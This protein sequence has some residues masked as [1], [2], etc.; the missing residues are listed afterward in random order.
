LNHSTI[1]SYPEK[2]MFPVASSSR[3][4]ESEVDVELNLDG[5]AGDQPP[6][7]QEPQVEVSNVAPA[8]KEVK[9]ACGPGGKQSEDGKEG[10]D[11]GSSKKIKGTEKDEQSGKGSQVRL[12]ESLQDSL[13]WSSRPVK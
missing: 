7:P 9:S 10:T 8:E 4:A 12:A 1:I 13:P 2:P 11:R 3:V 5:L 6:A